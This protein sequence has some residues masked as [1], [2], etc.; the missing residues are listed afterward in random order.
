M[1]PCTSLYVGKGS[2]LPTPKDP[3]R[4]GQSTATIV[5]VPHGE[6]RGSQWNEPLATWCSRPSDSAE[7]RCIPP[8]YRSWSEQREEKVVTD[9]EI[10]AVMCTW[11]ENEFM[12]G[13]PAS[14][15]ELLLRA[16]MDKHPSFSRHGARNLPKTWRS[17][18]GW[19]RV[20]PG[21]SRKLWVRAVWSRIACRMVEQGQHSIGLLVMTGLFS[22]ARRRAPAC[23]KVRPGASTSRGLAK[24]LSH[25][26]S[27]RNRQTNE[28]TN[29]QRYT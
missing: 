21:R 16:W 13:N 12:K 24:F 25:P 3:V 5:G 1:K 20:S 27:R 18:Q 10:D 7:L 26:G 28:S 8:E 17:L 11:M 4:R 9:A 23:K 14:S 6:R 2:N 15:R 29:A 22:N 19:Q